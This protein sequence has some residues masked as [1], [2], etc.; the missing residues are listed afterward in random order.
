[1]YRTIAA[2]T[3]RFP[4]YGARAVDRIIF[5][6]A[7][8]RLLRGVLAQANASRLRRLK[9][10][11]AVCV[12]C[13]LNIGDAVMTQAVAT[14][15]RAFLPDARIDFVT[16]ASAAC[17]IE[18]NPEIDRV[19]AA[20]RG[21]PF[22]DPQDLAAMNAILTEN[23][24]DL[25]FTF[26]PF[27]SR[28]SLRFPKGAAVIGLPQLAAEVVRAQSHA[29]EISHMT[30]RMFRFTHDLLSQVMRPLHPGGFVESRVTLNAGP[31]ERASRFLAAM[32]CDR[33]IILYNPDT[34]S[35]FTRVPVEFQ[36]RILSGLCDLPCCILLGEGHVY[37]RIETVLLDALRADQR[38]KIK[39]LPK[40]MPIDAYAVL[41]DSSDIFI[42][43]DTGPLHI[44]ASRKYARDGRH[45]FRNQT[46]VL[47]IYAAQPGRLYGYDSE[48]SGFLASS[49]NAEA[50]VYET[51][52][53]CRNMA[54]VNKARIACKD[55]GHFFQGLDVSA[56][57]GDARRIL[58]EAAA[59]TLPCALRSGPS[60]DDRQDKRRVPAPR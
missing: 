15:I 9:R 44:A 57:V 7:G 12:L 22:P 18:G 32:R 26:C 30:F 29:G 35:A 4:K 47:S 6:L 52:S 16:K 48:Q 54:T 24:Y 27:V 14:A 31:I 58:S 8:N 56:I 3:D 43:G 10:I 1:M 45:V 49:Q 41:I 46:A 37:P 2:I 19:F 20:Y 11:E 17:L 38:A 59:V 42:T 40:S 53:S 60:S 33:P 23:S 28:R 34:S 39:L 21:G 50:H 51:E 13:D 5:S 36:V 25:V 55:P